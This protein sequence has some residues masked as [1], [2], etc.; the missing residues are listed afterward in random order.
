VDAMMEMFKKFVTP[1]QQQLA[2]L[3]QQKGGD[4]I[5]KNERIMKELSD[6]EALISSP[7]SLKLSSPASV[8]FSSPAS[9]KFSSPASV[10]FSSPA[11]VMERP[12]HAINFDLAKIQQEIQDDPAKAIEKNAESFNRK[13]E[14]QKRHIKDDIERAVSRE[15]DRIISALEKGPHNRVLDPVRIFIGS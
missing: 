8:K 14:I 7:A 3:V 13:F 15:G 12:R 4:A 10:K 5:T 6:A 2:S 11:S 1:E 9:V